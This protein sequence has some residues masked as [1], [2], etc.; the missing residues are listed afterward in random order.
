MLPPCLRAVVVGCVLLAAR[1][2][3]AESNPSEVGKWSP[4]QSWP[5]SATHSILLPT[6]KVMLF[7]EFDEGNLPPL[8]WD[9]GS[10]QV[11]EL[12]HPGYNIFCAAHSF[13]EDGRLLVTG[14][15]V[16]AHV[17][18]ANASIF[19]PFTSQWQLL[20]DMNDRRWYPTNT[21]LATGE[22]VVLAGETTGP[23]VNNLLPQVF[24]PESN[25]WRDLVTAQRDLPYYPRAFLT[26]RGRVLMVGPRRTTVYLDTVGTGTWFESAN[27]LYGSRSYAPTLM[28]DGR[29][30]IVG[31]GDP[32]TA[33]SE[34]IDLMEPSPTW[35]YIAPMSVAR[36]QHNSVILPDGRVLIVGGSSGEGFNNR[37]A[38]VLHAEVWDPATDTWT[39]WA[40][41]SRFYGYHSTA[42]LLP[43]GR[44][45]LGG[46][47]HSHDWEIFSPPY[48]FKGTRPTVASAPEVVTPGTPFVIETP[49]A[50]HISKVTLI[51]LAAVTHSMDTNQ[52]LLTLP[53]E[54]NS[55]R[56]NIAAPTDNNLAPPGPYMLFLVD[57]QGVPSVGQMVRV[58]KVSPRTT[59][60]IIL[61]DTW[62][63]D[64][65]GVDR[66]TEW[67]ALNYDDSA[68]KSGPAQFGFGEGDEST[69][70]TPPDPATPTYYFR[71]KFTLDKLV[72]AATLE[73]LFDDGVAV[74]INGVL[75]F[76]ENVDTLGFASYASD[77]SDNAFIRKTLSL[78]PNPLVIGENVVTALVKNVGMESGDLSFALAL[79]VETQ[80]GPYPD[81]LTL[82][83]PN[84]G[85]HFAPGG[86]TELRWSARGSITTVDLAY[87]VDAGQTW[88]PI[89]SGV[90]NTGVY[91]WDLPWVQ[92]KQALVRIS[93]P[94]G[95][96]LS[97]TSD[98][99]FTISNEVR[100]QA[101]V[102]GDVWK[103]E[104]S[105]NDPGPTWNMPDF[106][107]AAWSAGHGK[108]GYGYHG[109][110]TLLTRTT[111]SQ[112]SVYFRKKIHVPGV[113][114]DARLRV[115]YDDGVAVYVNGALVLA[116]NM[117]SGFGHA[118]Y[119]SLSVNEAQE[120]V[121]LD[122]STN[123]FV[124]GENT[125]AVM[126]KQ[127]GRTS[128]DLIF[129]LSL[130]LGVTPPPPEAP[131]R[132]HDA[133]E[134]PA[135]GAGA[136]K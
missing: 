11:S 77:N 115:H 67:L 29:L 88:E 66:G 75:V 2:G 14:G 55:G 63:Y 51:S 72:T 121:S 21:V 109:L 7:G 15:H 87:S 19:N 16:D 30:L 132:R 1:T 125:L 114:T 12:P 102:L 71:K 13:L 65:S 56:L 94:D 32:P 78:S 60:A 20:P 68:W 49:N 9:P 34:W 26:P 54:V 41:A 133:G 53:F 37:D 70:L 91:T 134:T 45:L 85:E 84:G 106:D 74:W 24:Q 59:Q 92:T 28:L 95:T 130:E 10:G 107:D 126:V 82:L 97:D 105:G 40:S 96:L 33:T 116:R 64:D 136:P 57:A 122:L 3:W 73:V 99:V 50:E 103:Y 76:K 93:K 81:A 86:R 43:D 113:V 47:R 83:L 5:I 61:S 46:G 4:R 62:K 25:S 104:D 58:A 129:D 117:G 135:T 118:K 108:L 22:V 36:R 80:S 69:V 52:R 89:A 79:E 31:G 48:L 110:G 39:Q 112:T 18:L 27:R 38:P 90:P 101:A 131:A 35:R 124:Q 100:V 17:G 98:A 119:A 128:P 8:L 6:G 111:P 127:V 123:P 42:L 23:N 44:V 120:T